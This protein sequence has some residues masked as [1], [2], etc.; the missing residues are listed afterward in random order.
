MEL[1]QV[2]Y[3]LALAEEC[4]FGR[5]A[6]RLHVAQPAL[7]QQI[8]QLERELGI[9]LFHRSTRHVE[10]TEAG[11][12]LT[13][14][15]RTLLAEAERARVHMTELATGHAGHVSVGFIGTATYDVLPRVAR[16]VRAR[17]PQITLELRGE[18]LTPQLGEGLV[19]GA[20]NLA[21]F[22]S[23]APAEGVRVTPLRTEPLVAVLPA[24]HPLAGARRIPLGSLAGE[25]FVIHPAQPRS[26]MYDR[27]LA[28]CGRAGFQPA[29]LVEVGETA[30]LVVLVAAGHGVALVP[31][32]VQSLRLD[33]VTYVPLAETETV[34]LV[35]GRRTQRTSPAA[36]QVASVI[37]ECVQG[38]ADVV[39]PK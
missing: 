10:L 5:A 15:A 19:T 29:S 34:D 39:P 8:K 18:L 36:E 11:H 13:G 33:G 16:T 1:R 27:V 31:E 9:E 3:F 2:R 22:R 28:A 17:L 12:Q 23:G 26:A 14:Y 20:Y 35:L 24:A 38:A 6:A 21:V 32:S 37:E 30:T 25:P 4:H 7:S